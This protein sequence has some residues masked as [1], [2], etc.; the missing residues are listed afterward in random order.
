MNETILSP[1]IAQIEQLCAKEPTVPSYEASWLIRTL[2][3]KMAECEA[4]KKE[5]KEK[6]QTIAATIEVIEELRGILKGVLSVTE[7][8]RQ[9]S[10]R[11]AL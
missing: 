10:E 5:L 3:A 9:E 6:D 1:R 7:T 4:L 8:T 11:T 2:R